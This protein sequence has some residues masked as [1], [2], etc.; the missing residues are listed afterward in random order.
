MSKI[1]IA[2][3]SK[4]GNTR[5]MAELLKDRVQGDLYEIT[6]NRRY[7]DNDW[8]AMDEANAEI[9]NNDLPPVTSAPIN[10]SPYDTILIGGPVWGWTLSTPLMSF[11]NAT[12]LAGR[13]VSAF[14]TFYDHDEKYDKTMKAMIGN[15]EYHSGLPMPRSLVANPAKLNT[16]IDKW[17]K[18]II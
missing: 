8:T 3:Y 7:S 4:D 2:F 14:W 6:T 9:Q 12:D 13:K 18:Q 10:L 17:L 15:G 5:R 11:L 16:A 1:L